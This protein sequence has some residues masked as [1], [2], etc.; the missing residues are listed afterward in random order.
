MQNVHRQCN[1]AEKETEMPFKLHRKQDCER[2]R[3]APVQITHPATSICT[4]FNAARRNPSRILVLQLP[5]RRSQ[6]LCTTD[7]DQVSH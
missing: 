4:E 1:D 3:F 5:A 6:Q 7:A 2:G